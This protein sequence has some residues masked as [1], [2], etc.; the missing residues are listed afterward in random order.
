MCEIGTKRNVTYLSIVFLPFGHIESVESYFFLMY[1]QWYNRLNLT[2]QI[3]SL[4]L[5]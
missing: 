1:Q 4:I 3:K 5:E 2:S